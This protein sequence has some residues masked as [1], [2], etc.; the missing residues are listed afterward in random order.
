MKLSIDRMGVRASDLI[1]KPSANNKSAK[2]DHN[3]LEQALS[4]VEIEWVEND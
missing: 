3:S 1:I 4:K 2:V